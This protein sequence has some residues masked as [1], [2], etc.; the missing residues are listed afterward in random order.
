MGICIGDLRIGAILALICAL[1]SL[2]A[3][4]D[5][6]AE[7]PPADFTARQYIDSKGC[8]FLRDDNGVWQPRRDRDETQLCGY[9]PTL[10]ARRLTPDGPVKLFPRSGAEPSRSQQIESALADLVIPNLQTGEL[11]GERAPMQQRLD[12]GPEPSSNDPLLTLRAEI[13]SQGQ[14]RAQMNGLM[15]PNLDLCRLLGYDGKPPADVAVGMQPGADPTGGFCN[16]L[17]RNDLARLAFARPASLPLPPSR[18]QVPAIAETA[19]RD[20]TRGAAAGAATHA[21]QDAKPKRPRQTGAASPSP[22]PVRTG[23]GSEPGVK[24]VT[25]PAPR[26]QPGQE[27][28][29]IPA[30]ARFVLIGRFRQG[31]DVDLIAR[32]LSGL[33]LPVVRQIAPLPANGTAW[34]VLVG[35][36]DSRQ[37]IVMALDRVRKA[38][39]TWAVPR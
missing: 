25:P 28:D 16:A 19:D 7:L 27:A 23:R 29:G 4:A 14:I 21:A 39:F 30:S 9:P 6:P 24:A 22:A 26:V 34:I 37:S 38:G 32:R 36:F 12:A 1:F 10:S 5:S 2:A 8:V 33:G 31:Q 17:P 18:D 15:Q 11:A 20:T 13:E 3:L 35:P